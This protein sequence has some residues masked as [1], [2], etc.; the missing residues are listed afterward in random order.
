LAHLA[1]PSDLFSVFIKHEGLEVLL[2]SLES[3]DSDVRRHSGAAI[4]KLDAR[5][6]M[7]VS[8][9][10]AVRKKPRVRFACFF[11]F[12][13]VDEGGGSAIECRGTL[14]ATS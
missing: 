12:K 8:E 14:G 4:T 2:R 7:A 9:E 5:A 11:P 6:R 10:P 13:L 3:G 1:K